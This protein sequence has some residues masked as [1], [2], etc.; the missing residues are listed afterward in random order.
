M[1][2]V[3]EVVGED[4]C[5]V[6]PMALVIW[7]YMEQIANFALYSAVFAVRILK[8]P[9]NQFMDFYFLAYLIRLSY[10]PTF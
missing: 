5:I 7:I 9:I 4:E 1:E 8:E 3:V 2:D 10:A 6:I